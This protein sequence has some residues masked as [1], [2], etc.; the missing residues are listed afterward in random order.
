MSLIDD[1]IKYKQE[2][3]VRFHMPG[4]KGNTFEFDELERLR[5]HLFS[6]DVTEV[7]GTD[8]LHVPNG[9]IKNAQDRAKEFYGAEHSFFF[10]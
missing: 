6:I 10:S 7:E 5:E 4:H 3:D 8:N 1:L 2:V 9:I